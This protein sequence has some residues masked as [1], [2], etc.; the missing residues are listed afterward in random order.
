MYSRALEWPTLTTQ[1]LPDVQEVPGKAF[2]THK[3]VL[4][5]HTSEQTVDYLQIA[6]VNLPNPPAA[7]LADYN[8]TTEELG[9]YGA[10]KEPITFS[11]VH[12][13]VHPTEVNKA[14]Y[15]PQN[16]YIIATWA[17]D[18]NVYIWDRSKHPAIPPKENVPMPQATLKGH[19]KEGACI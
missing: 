11:V 8:E 13:I 10:A 15:Q 3:L 16:P 1:W 14:R 18:K 5:T 19:K 7:T 9:G 6:H 17:S 4:G 12:K 2:R